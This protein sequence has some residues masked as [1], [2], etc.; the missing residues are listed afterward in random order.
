[1]R[2][3]VIL[4]SVAAVGL[5]SAAAPAVESA[6]RTIVDRTDVTAEEAVSRE[7]AGTKGPIGHDHGAHEHGPVE[8]PARAGTADEVATDASDGVTLVSH[9]PFDGIDDLFSGGTD[10]AFDGKYVYAAQFG[11]AGGVH[12]FN[13]TGHNPQK[14]GFFDCPGTQNDVAVL[15]DGLI[16]LGFHEGGQEGTDCEEPGGGVRIIDVSDPA[17][18]VERGNVLDIPGGTHTIKV[19]PELPIIYASPGGMAT[20]GGGPLSD[21]GVQQIIDA[22]D[23]DAP[24]VRSQFQPNPNGCHDVYLSVTDERDRDLIACVGLGESQL[25]D[26]T[27]D[28]FAPRTIARIHNPLIFFDH[29]AAISDDGDLLVIGDENFGAHECEGGPTGAM[30]AYD[31]SVPELPVLQG[32]FGIDRH[33]GD[34]PHISSSTIERETWCTAHQ[35]DFIPGTRTMVASWY[36]GGMNVIDWSDPTSPQELAHYRLDG[37]AFENSNYWSAY[38]H[39]GYVYANDRGRGMDILHVEGLPGADDPKRAPRPRG[40]S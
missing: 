4:A 15:G 6:L 19:H 32:Y 30:F 24:F 20:N 11:D 16:V 25:W 35:Y 23:P 21:G 39:D 9:F 14:V 10:L 17:N 5:L 34:D 7:L 31:I 2:K 33:P 28:P 12:I 13:A 36:T 38:W 37:P 26:I 8:D 29:S 40:R 3:L 27:D 22:S 18:P 1:M